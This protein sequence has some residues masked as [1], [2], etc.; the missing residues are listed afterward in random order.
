MLKLTQSFTALFIVVSMAVDT[1]SVAAMPVPSHQ[2]SFQ[3]QGREV[4]SKKAIQGFRKE[5]EQQPSS[6]FPQTGTFPHVAAVRGSSLASRQ[7]AEVKR[8]LLQARSATS[9]EGTSDEGTSS[10]DKADLSTPTPDPTSP[11]T[12]WVMSGNPTSDANQVKSTAL[13]AEDQGSAVTDNVDE[14][15]GQQQQQLSGLQTKAAAA[16]ALDDDPCSLPSN[17]PRLEPVSDEAVSPIATTATSS[18]EEGTAHTSASASSLVKGL[19]KVGNIFHT[20]GG[21]PTLQNN[22][23]MYRR[24]KEHSHHRQKKGEGSMGRSSNHPDGARKEKFASKHVQS[25]KANVSERGH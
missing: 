19:T 20:S 8:S 18:V 17:T 5:P 22:G 6:T 11:P 12:G 2:K 9:L 15:S 4:A 1:S 7:A 10:A 13:A 14:Y 25:S 24:S 16:I 3:I 23:D 21:D